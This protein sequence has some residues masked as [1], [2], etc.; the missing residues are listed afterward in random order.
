MGELY[1]TF[2]RFPYLDYTLSPTVVAWAVALTV[3]ATF[4][5]VIRAVQRA[6]KLP[7]A[8]AMRPAP[9]AS[10][11]P[12]FIERI[13]LQ[14]FLDQPTRMILRN[15]ERQPVKAL[16]TVV[17]IASSCS[18]LIM[19][20]CFT[21]AFDYIIRVQ[22]GIAQ[23]DDLTVSFAEPTSTDA[24]YELKALPGVVHA[25]PFRMAPVTLRHQH[26]SYDTG[27]EGIPRDAYLRRIVDKQLKPV[28]IPTEGIV[29]TVRLG[30]IL[31]VER[32]E[33]IVVEALEGN[34]YVREVQVVDFTEQ[35]LGVAAYMDLDALNRLVGGGQAISGAFLSTDRPDEDALTAELQRRPRV[36]GIVAQERAIASFMETSAESML[37]FTFILSL[38]AGVIAFGVV[39]NSARIAL[40]ERDRELASLRV[41]GF[42]QGEIAYI[43]LGELGVLT[44]LAIPLGFG[45]GAAMSAGVVQGLQTD[46]YQIPLVLGRNVF[47]LSAVVVLLAS[48][49]SA[50]IVRIKLA[51]LDLV[52]V[53]K[54]R[55]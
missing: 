37:T 28:A 44:L 27:I 47:A 52:G 24:L 5:G 7:P 23:R 42:T 16:L 26:R 51:K 29:L 45:M 14:R 4:A 54:T 39:Y 11:K 8:E 18:I 53:L 43:L 6:V 49:I 2:Y 21:D 3:G 13:G 17:G 12:T 31:D 36:I 35:Y 40:S 38:F 33:T 48:A 46:L 9:P 1:L 10:Y 41:L 22:Y 32:G 50:I 25:E 19:G 55:E 15:L 20:L 30:E 34:R